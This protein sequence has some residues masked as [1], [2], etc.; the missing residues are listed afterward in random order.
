MGIQLRD[1]RP[2]AT[3]MRELLKRRQLLPDTSSSSAREH[4]P[5]AC[6]RGSAYFI[7]PLS[8]AVL[9]RKKGP[10]RRRDPLAVPARSI[11]GL[12]LWP[13]V[14][15][16]SANWGKP[17]CCLGESLPAVIVLAETRLAT[18]EWISVDRYSMNSD[19]QDRKIRQIVEALGELAPPSLVTALADKLR[20]KMACTTTS[21]RSSCVTRRSSKPQQRARDSSLTASGSSCVCPSSLL[22]LR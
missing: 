8:N 16:C 20:P 1:S 10:R 2:A 9:R 3:R 11:G 15:V 18:P 14:S 21:K 4:E 12:G 7:V 22:P 13:L 19:V 17:L 6:L 5:L